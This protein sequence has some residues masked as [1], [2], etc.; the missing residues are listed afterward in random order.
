M[1]R[2]LFI[3]L[4]LSAVSSCIAQTDTFYYNLSYNLK[5]VKKDDKKVSYLGKVFKI[6]ST[7]SLWKVEE[8]K[9]WKNELYATGWAKD[10][11][12]NIKQGKWKY[13][14]EDQIVRRAGIFIDNKREGEWYNWYLNG[15]ISGR[16]TFLNGIPV[17]KSM[18]WYESGKLRDSALLDNEGN[19]HA[20]NYQESG[21]IKATGDLAAGIKSGWWEYYYDLPGSPKSMEVNYVSDSMQSCKCFTANGESSKK[22]CALNIYDSFPGGQKAWREYLKEKIEGI[23]FAN[24]VEIAKDYKVVVSFVINKEGKVT[25]I[26]MLRSG[27]NEKL[28]KLALK[29]I[30]AS[31][32]WEPALQYNQPSGTLYQQ[33]LTFAG[34]GGD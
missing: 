15:K 21:Q 30:E 18:G 3:I 14:G 4:F 28:D 11:E 34:T 7:D 22:T 31:P 6:N 10:A 29:V 1:K 20:F 19:G 26:K 33:P 23:M 27:H 9:T 16:N 24:Q 32:D 25:E 2:F 8:Y 12:G 5:R 17:G 13:F